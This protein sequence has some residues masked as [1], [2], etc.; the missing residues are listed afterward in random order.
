MSGTWYDKHTERTKND[1]PSRVVVP[2]TICAVSRQLGVPA[3]FH[4]IMPFIYG[5]GVVFAEE[6]FKLDTDTLMHAFTNA[7]Q[8]KAICSV[9]DTVSPL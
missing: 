4:W 5:A 3:Q 6:G 7:M 2:A 9:A 8:A 1:I